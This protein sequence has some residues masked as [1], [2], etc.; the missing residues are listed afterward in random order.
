MRVFNSMTGTKE[1]LVPAEPP[2]VKMYVCGV[3]PYDMSHLGHARTYVTFDVVSRYLRASGY[4]VVYV[5]NFTDVEDKI[6]KKANA[7]GVAPLSLADRFI[8][9]Y[10]ADMNALSVA[11]ADIEPK[12]STSMPE[13]LKLIER[14]VKNGSAYVVDGDVYFSVD[15]F[16]SYLKLSKRSAEDLEA[17]ARVEVDAR[18]KNPMDFALW[19][20]AKP[21][22]PTWDSPWGKGRPGWHIEC[23]AMAFTHLG[24][25]IDIHGGGR[26]LLFPHHENEIAQS[27]AASH[28]PF[29]KYWMHAGLLNVDDTKMSKSLGNFFTIRE[30]LKHVDPEA[31]RLFFLTAHYRSPLNFELDK[32]ADGNVRF[33][34]IEEAAKRLSYIYRT[35]G[36]ADALTKDVVTGEGPVL[37]PELVEGAWSTFC[38]DMD[39]DF[40]TAAAISSLSPLLS[41]LNELCDKPPKPRDQALRTIARLAQELRRCGAVLGILAADPVQKNTAR[42]KALVLLRKID[43]A[44]VESLMVDRQLARAEKRFADADTLRGQ[45]SQLG[46]VIKDSAQGSF[47]EISEDEKP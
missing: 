8:A 23:S 2:K 45:L 10:D 35:L 34:G 46:V 44:Q 5:R 1:E 42:Q 26:D 15:A 21:G 39:D 6:I 19:K 36:K 16:P 3:T 40:N 27:E 12:V 43:V 17:G 41:Y 30:V 4:Q 28:Q 20:S 22:E 38:K 25:T 9:E 11:K 37:R 33:V 24:E 7:E 29:A 32:G 47:W 31:M 18:K 14:L 13:I